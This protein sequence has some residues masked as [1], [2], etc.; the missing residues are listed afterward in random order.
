MCRR[1]RQPAPAEWLIPGFSRAAADVCVCAGIDY[2]AIHLWPDNW[3]RVDQD[4][5]R[6]WLSNHS[7]NGQMLNKPV[8]LE[9]FGK[10]GAL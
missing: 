6:I 2:A 10:V 8:V 5:G 4:F 7:A 1:L 9:E 3:K